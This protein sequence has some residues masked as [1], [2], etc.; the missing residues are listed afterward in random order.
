MNIKQ[1]LSY[2]GGG[3]KLVS[4]ADY[5]KHCKFIFGLLSN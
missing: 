1:Q 2:L 4:V 3:K 5:Q